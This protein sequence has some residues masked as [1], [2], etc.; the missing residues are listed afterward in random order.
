MNMWNCEVI[1]MWALL[2]VSLI[3]KAYETSVGND[4]SLQDGCET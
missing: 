3:V 2:S 1:F 4:T